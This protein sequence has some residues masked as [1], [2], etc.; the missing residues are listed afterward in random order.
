[1]SF[2]C[3]QSQDNLVAFS[4]DVDSAASFFNSSLV[5]ILGSLTISLFKSYIGSRHSLVLTLK[6]K[7]KYF[8]CVQSAT[9]N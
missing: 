3:M 8:G 4:S 7:L 1:M 6:V 5:I 2:G 9:C